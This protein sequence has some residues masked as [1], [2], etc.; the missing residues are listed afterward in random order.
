MSEATLSI[1]EVAD[2]AGIA[3]S[4]IRYYERNGLL[5]E[6]ERVSGQ[7]R[8][9]EE[10]VQ[11]L[12]V[13]D[14]AKQAG[15]SLDE[16]RVLLTS[17]DAG[18]PAHE[19]LQALAERK[20]PEVDALIK[21]AQA[22]RDWLLI[23]SDCGCE[24][25]EGCL[26]FVGDRPLQNVSAVVDPPVTSRDQAIQARGRELVDLAS[27]HFPQE[28]EVAGDAT[29]FPLIGTALVSR[30]TG[31]MKAILA[32]Q[33]EGR[34]ADA[35]TLLRSLYE[36]AV[37]FGWLAADPSAE[38]IQEW[39]KDDLESRLKADA[40]LRERGEPILTDDERAGM[41]RQV[42]GL[43]GSGLVPL[44]NLAVAADKR[45]E[46]ELPGMGAHGELKSFR[47][48]YALLYRS[49]S[50]FAHPTF[51]GQNVVAAEVAPGR[52]RA[53]LEERHEGTGPYGMATLFFGFG[54]YLASAALD[55]PDAAEISAIFDR[56]PG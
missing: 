33:A 17:I 40:D 53:W 24:T 6:A 23:A 13:I 21:R 18:A 43:H 37:H 42:A 38:R 14:V 39:K 8:F 44:T 4:A 30:M 10:T 7:R 11:R 36:H 41:E 19:Q 34:E 56:H 27:R 50:G 48:F 31:T 35:G 32:L 25:L 45:W 16:V 3:V 28:F 1:G 15:F 20:L 9:T 54:L 46:G 29:A 49:N 55:W 2:R 22:M 26:L 47:G 12:G 51:R 5:P 52:Q